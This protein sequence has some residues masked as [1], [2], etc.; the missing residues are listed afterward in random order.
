MKKKKGNV[1]IIVLI[2]ILI[3]AAIL[4]GLGLYNSSPQTKVRKQISLGNR[5]Y[6]EMD[7]DRAIA[8]YTEAL[9]IDPKNVE[10]KTALG[11]TYRARGAE[12]AEQSAEDPSQREKAVQDLET[13]RTYYEEILTDESLPEEK[14]KDVSDKRQETVTTIITIPAAPEA[15]AGPD[16]QAEGQES[17]AGA[18]EQNLYQAFHGISDEEFLS[19]REAKR[20]EM[21]ERRD[22]AYQ[23]DGIDVGYG[24]ERYFAGEYFAQVLEQ[25]DGYA[26]Y[27]FEPWSRR[28]SS[29]KQMLYALLAAYY[30]DAPEDAEI[31]QHTFS[32]LEAQLSAGTVTLVQSDLYDYISGT[33][34]D[35]T[36]TNSENH[37]SQVP[38]ASF[39]EVDDYYL[40]EVTPADGSDPVKLLFRDYNYDNFWG[41]M[42]T[43]EPLE[44]VKVSIHQEEFPLSEDADPAHVGT[45]VRRGFVDIIVLRDSIFYE[46]YY[47]AVLQD[48]ADYEQCVIEGK[49]TKVYRDEKKLNVLVY[50]SKDL[51]YRFL[52]LNHD[53]FNELIIARG[54]GDRLRVLDFYTKGEEGPVHV[55]DYYGYYA[56]SDRYSACFDIDN[57]Q[58]WIFGS[59][60]AFSWYASIYNFDPGATGAVFVGQY[61]HDTRENP[62]Y[63]YMDANKNYSPSTEEEFN[64]YYGR[65]DA[66]FND[67]RVFN[68]ADWKLVREHG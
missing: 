32:E 57:N 67:P 54:D 38:A 35:Y 16:T 14:K 34:K 26:N 9:E 47:G 23:I 17:Q 22:A 30:A 28:F 5:Y 24:A 58:V 39:T 27:N 11:D 36:R 3:V 42:N 63:Q 20:G 31:R 2:A 55:M 6:E 41:E 25:A 13:A 4:L 52:D 19:S 29:S 45:E 49:D 68:I 10:A 65:R 59:G 8:A 48:Y 60:S 44:N 43:R 7:Y 37:L 50:Y 33:L 53:G 61:Y 15:E 1:L 46:Q 66:M 62:E 21:E 64:Q 40:F 51:Y 18:A 56:L 12:Y